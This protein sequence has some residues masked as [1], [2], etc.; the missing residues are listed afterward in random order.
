MSEKV[1]KIEIPNSLRI[2]LQMIDPV[3]I[4]ISVTYGIR[5]QLKGNKDPKEISIAPDIS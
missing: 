4:I 3:Y 1:T 2:Y 5:G